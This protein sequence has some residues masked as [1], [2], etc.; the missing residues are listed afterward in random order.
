MTVVYGKMLTSKRQLITAILFG[1]IVL[2]Y[3][4]AVFSTFK[5][6][7][8][9]SDYGELVAFALTLI[10]GSVIFALGYASVIVFGGKT[11]LR[12]VEFISRFNGSKHAV[13]VKEEAKANSRGLINYASLLY[14]PALILLIALALAL[15]IHYLDATFAVTFQSF[16]S[17]VIQGILV[18]LDIFLKPTSIGSLRYS[19]EIIPIMVSFVAIAGVVPSIVFPYLR[20]FKITS[21]NGVPFHKDILFNIIGAAFGITIVLS[22]VNI[23]YGVLIGT[24][25]HYYSYVLPT[26]LGF[27]LHYFL[28]IYVGREKAEKMIENQLRTE[29]RKRVFQGEII[30]L[31]RPTNQAE[32]S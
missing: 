2:L 15:N 3:I 24:Q 27:S 17:P 25:P 28:G 10:G 31:E 23:I 13:E 20:K 21:V 14:I 4:V 16:P 26:I 6:R 11:S 9:G 8:S 1:L 18:A 12:L 5:P 32:K 30:I 22:L 7:N 29:P 19:I